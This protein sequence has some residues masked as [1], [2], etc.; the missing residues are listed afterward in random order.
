MFNEMSAFEVAHH[1]QSPDLRY[2]MGF[3]SYPSS[4]DNLTNGNLS[5]QDYDW[6]Q[7]P[8]I[9]NGGRSMYNMTQ[10]SPDPQYGQ[11]TNY[12]NL[13]HS[14]VT[15]MT[16]PTYI[17]ASEMS[18]STPLSHMP[19][20]G[21]NFYHQTYSSVSPTSSNSSTGSCNS[22]SNGQKPKRKRVQSVV[23]RKAANVRERRRMFHLNEAFDEL[24]KR[25]PAFNYEKR[26]S[27]IE[28]L[29]LAMT[30]IA[31]MKD[32]SDGKEPDNVQLIQIQRKSEQAF[33]DDEIDS[34]SG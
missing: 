5:Y 31:F 27:R 1:E 32:V 20:P 14:E 18:F 9:G 10:E 29:R 34:G 13:A 23:Q 2:D 22:G 15:L 25:L 28:T 8:D 3:T 17:P 6:T 26:L 21:E 16:Q 7:G 12:S 19:Y 11:F 4:A 24:R 30:Y 33:L